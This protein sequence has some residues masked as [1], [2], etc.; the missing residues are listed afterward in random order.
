MLARLVCCRLL[1]EAGLSYADVGV[2]MRLSASDAE[3]D[4]R[5]LRCLERKHRSLR[6]DMDAIGFEAVAWELGVECDQF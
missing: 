3:A 5:L 4:V 2:A 6:R 1:R